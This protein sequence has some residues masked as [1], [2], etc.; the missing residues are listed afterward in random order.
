MRVTKRVGGGGIFRGWLVVAACFLCMLVSGGI[1][2]FT[3][4]VF[5]KPLQD[6]FAW[7]RFQIGGAV[8]L[9]AAVGAVF[10]PVLGHFIDRFGSRRIMLAAVALG[11]LVTLAMG[12]IQALSHLYL[13]MF[14][15][16]LTTGASTYVPVTSVI[17]QWFSKRRG[18]AMSIAMVGMGIGGFVMP[19]VSSF[20][21]RTVGWRWTYR[22]FSAVLWLILLPAVAMWLYGRPSDVG[23]T[24]DGDESPADEETRALPREAN[25]TGFS[26]REALTM[27]RFWFLGLADVANAIPVV[28]LGLYMVDFSIG[29]GIADN[30][31][32]FAYSSISAAAIAGM[33]AAG[34]AADRFNRRI[35]ISVCY[36]LPAV[37]ILLLFGLKSAGPLFCYALFSGFCGGGRSA[38][39]PLVVNDCFG[40]RAYG[41]VVGFLVIFYNIG[42]V[43]GPPAAGFIRDSTESFNLVFVMGIAAYIVAG[44]AMA[45]GAK[46]VS[47]RKSAQADHAV[48]SII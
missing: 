6:E 19:N 7:T 47:H 16:A 43:V 32:A 34:F 5:I 36:G 13:A 48:E 14:F 25:A 38:L 22:I 27:G 24:P 35:M 9:W 28:A 39:W 37:S 33:I 18:I 45:F 11:G 15:A 29:A 26:A 4:P 2:W 12:Q 21:V 31:A 42:A 10:S 46:T 17:S 3:F 40:S 41:T 23:S 8:G 44:I 20:L 30:V 1:G